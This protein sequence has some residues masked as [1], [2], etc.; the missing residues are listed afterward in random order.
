MT[1]KKT[2]AEIDAAQR[3]RLSE[4]LVE[5]A[6]REAP[7]ALADVGASAIVGKVID[8]F[9]RVLRML[10]DGTVLEPVPVPAPGTKAKRDAPSMVSRGRVIEMQHVAQ[11]RLIQARDR[12]FDLRAE[13]DRAKVRSWDPEGDE[14]F[15]HR[16]EEK[17][18]R[19]INTLERHLKSYEDALA[20]NDD[21]WELTG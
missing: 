19:L 2:A 17:E 10:G 7:R 11:E 3:K 4:V 8:D 21:S 14:R 18:A 5:A 16:K 1:G 20:S 12:L 15:F 13:H 6:F 9:V